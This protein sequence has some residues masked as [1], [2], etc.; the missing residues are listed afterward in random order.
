MDKKTKIKK[1]FEVF[2]PDLT[3]VDFVEFDSQ[4]NNQISKLKEALKEKI[5]AQTLDDVN[6]QLEKFRKTIDV[7]PFRQ[8]VD[9]LESSLDQ[10]IKGI[11]GL[12]ES[13]LGDFQTLLSSQEENTKEQISTTASDIEVLKKELLFLN[14][15]KSIDLEA[16]KK[17]LVELDK[18]SKTADQAYVEIQ[19]TFEEIRHEFKN[20][21][22]KIQ[23]NLKEEGKKELEELVEKLEVLRKELLTRIGNLPHGGNMNRNIA[24]GGNTSVLSKY[25]DINIKPGSNVVLTYSNNDVTKYLDLT[26]ASSGG[27]VGGTVRSINRVATS[28]TMGSVSGTDYVY[29]AT[30]GIKL[31]LPDATGIT[32][33]YTIKNV[34]AS[35]VLVATTAA[36][37]I[38]G[39]SELILATQFTAVDLVND[40]AD[41]WGIT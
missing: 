9:G 23:S 41:D 3:S 33:L 34:A 25:T 39:S 13:K 40:G 12:L 8:A 29:I 21:D 27:S 11:S 15:Q 22:E 36:Q 1:I 26:I 16:I 5:Q 37:T 14:D 28:Q 32:N 24:V 38:D 30:A 20:E 31:T 17:Q 7:S 2:K 6:R 4:I 10:K 18:F 35:S 19:A